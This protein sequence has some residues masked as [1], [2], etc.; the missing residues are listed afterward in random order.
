MKI[1]FIVSK[2]PLLSET[3]ILNQITGLIDLGHEVDIYAEGK[4]DIT[5]VH[6]D[7]EKYNLINHTYYIGKPNNRVWRTIK[8]LG[9]VAINLHRNPITLFHSL[10]I[11]RYG[12]KAKNLDLFYAAIHL[13]KKRKNYDIIHGH[14]GPNGLK[15]CFLREAGILNG[16]KLITTFYGNDVSEYVKKYGNNVY[17]QL[18]SKGDYFLCLS[19]FMKYQLIELGCTSEKL[20]IHSLGIDC[21]K[22]YFTP[23]K[24]SS[25]GTVKLLTIARLVDKKGVEYA[26]RAIAN[27]VDRSQNIQLQYDVVGDGY[28][29]EELQNLIEQLNIST[30]ITLLGWKKQQ[31]VVEILNQSHALIVPSVTGKRGD[32]EG[33][34]TVLME[35]MAMGLP[36]VSTYHSGIPE[37]VEDGVTG[38]LVPERDVDALAEKLNYLIEHPEIWSEMGLAGRKFVEEN[39]DINKLNDK[40]V[41]IYQH[42]LNIRTNDA[43]SISK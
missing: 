21:S 13:L 32:Q 28:L 37:V 7:V 14:F 20:F 2:F 29:R 11:F 30:N 38:F 25:D 26:I 18:F 35:G 4:G 27:I 10:N 24:K 23:R 22:F 19:N 31:E 33:T 17:K 1:A 6:S 9:L 3:F 34:P 39:Y 43:L 42:L 36:I 8:M 12:E 41:T 15:G 40:L 5:K 16:K